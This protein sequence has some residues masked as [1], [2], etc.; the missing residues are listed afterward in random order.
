MLIDGL[1]D[2][3]RSPTFGEKFNDFRHQIQGA[4]VMTKL[5]DNPACPRLHLPAL[6]LCLVHALSTFVYGVEHPPNHEGLTT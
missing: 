2:F 5:V 6:S 3:W 4:V 1:Y